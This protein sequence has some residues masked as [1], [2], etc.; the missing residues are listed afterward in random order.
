MSHEPLVRGLVDSAVVIGGGTSGLGLA[1]AR[2]FA[3]A[4][5]RGIALLARDPQRGQAAVETVRGESSTTD[6]RFIRADARDVDDVFASVEQAHEVFGAIDVLVSATAATASPDLIFRIPPTSIAEQLLAPAL[7]PM[8]LTR[9][10]FPIM[11]EQGGGAIINIASD[12]AKVPTPGESVL[13]GAMAAIAMFSRGVALEGRRN[14]IR[15]NVVT[16]SII[17]GTPTTEKWLSGGFSKRLFEGAIQAA[18]LGVVDAA[19]LA[20]LV[21]FLAS[22]AAAKMTGQAISMNGAISVA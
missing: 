19:E 2:R 7:P 5:A 13:G 4:G 20:E 8:L 10:V 14:G 9:A 17:G 3:R 18:S 12:A 6:V 22:P 11:Q 21:V 16:P 1:T 15:V